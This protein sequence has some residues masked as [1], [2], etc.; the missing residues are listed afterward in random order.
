MRGWNLQTVMFLNQ[1]TDSFTNTLSR[2]FIQ[3]TKISIFVLIVD[4]LYLHYTYSL[5]W[6]RWRDLNPQGFL[7][8]PLKRA[9][10]PIPPHRHDISYGTPL[11]YHKNFFVTNINF[12]IDT[13]SNIV[14]NNNIEQCY[15]V[16][17][18]EVLLSKEVIL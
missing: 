7:H 11:C 12:Y 18:F 4:R 2:Y 8:T 17:V 15:G 9:R 3:P 16:S 13:L 14:Q 1:I 5:K 6:C 10:I